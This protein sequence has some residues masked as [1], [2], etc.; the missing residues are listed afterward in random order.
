[1]VAKGLDRVAAVVQGI[2][3][4]FAVLPAVRRPQF[5]P[6]VVSVP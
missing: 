5:P 6:E 1:V 2:T 4:M 3:A